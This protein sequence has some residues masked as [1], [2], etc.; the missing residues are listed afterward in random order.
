MENNILLVKPDLKDQ[1]RLVDAISNDLF[2]NEF[3]VVATCTKHLSVAEF[4]NNFICKNKEH[5]EYMTSGPVVSILYKGHS[6]VGF[7]RNYKFE[8]RKQHKIDEIRNVLH[9]TEPG[10][11]FVLQFKLFFSDLNI[12]DHHQFSDQGVYFG[13]L[14]S[15]KTGQLSK[16][17]CFNLIAANKEEANCQSFKKLSSKNNCKYVGIRELVHSNIEILT[18][19]RKE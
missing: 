2:K 4:K 17:A 9:T 19:R 7:G 18:Y 15:A 1:E 6:A 11:E 3:E 13:D 16:L 8:F 10:N 5:E 12:A 14:N